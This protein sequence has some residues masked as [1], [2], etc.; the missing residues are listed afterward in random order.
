MRESRLYGSVRG[1]RGNSRPYR[2]VF[3]CTSSRR[4]LAHNVSAAMS[5]FTES[6]EHYSKGCSVGAQEHAIKFSSAVLENL[7]GFD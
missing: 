5:A 7:G 1:A 3:C 4:V 6:L 2:E